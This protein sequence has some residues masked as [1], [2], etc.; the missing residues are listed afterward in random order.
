[1][2]KNETTVERLPI[3]PDQTGRWNI[4]LGG[5]VERAVLAISGL[6]PGTMETARYWFAVMQK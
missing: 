1:L 4:R 3:A 2:S 5:D 6:T